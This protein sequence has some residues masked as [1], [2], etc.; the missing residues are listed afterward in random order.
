MARSIFRWVLIGLIGVVIVGGVSLYIYFDDLATTHL[1]AQGGVVVEIPPGAG[2]DEVTRLLAAAEVTEHPRLLRFYLKIKGLDTELRAG[3]FELPRPACFADIAAVLTSDEVVTRRFTLPE[4]LTVERMAAAL[5]DQHVCDAE[6]FL[7]EATELA[8]E[9]LDLDSAEGYLFPDTYEAAV[10]A[11]AAEIA[12]LL[13]DQ[14]ARVWEDEAGAGLDE[15]E[16]HR[17][18]TLASIV[19][20]EGA[21]ATEFPLIA[22]VFANRLE[23]GMKLES[24]ATVLHALGEHKQ[25]LEYR[26][27][28][29][30]SPY[31]TYRVTGLPPGPVCCPGREAIAAALNPAEHDYLFF[32]SNGDGTHTFSRTLAEHNA[33]RLA[34]REDRAA[35]VDPERP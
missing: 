34:T 27:L 3:T 33:A 29:V 31:N 18:L 6:S 32:V 25:V 8:R 2:A 35:A 22:G 7:A 10:D 30:D 21:A 14:A 24:C 1:E 12:R 11:D 13:F 28:E 20:A 26:D 9:E 4:G 5:E 19:Q 23:R 17:L 15:A 16:R